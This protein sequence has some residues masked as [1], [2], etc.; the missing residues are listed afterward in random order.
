MK[1]TSFLAKRGKLWLF[2]YSVY[3]ALFFIYLLFIL[4]LE[5]YWAEINITVSGWVGID[6]N[7]ILLI[8]LI[9]LA[10]L[11]YG[12]ILLTVNFRRFITSSEK[13]PHM[14]HKILPFFLIILYT[15]LIII[16][17]ELLEDYKYVIFQFFEFYSYFIFLGLDIGLLLLLYPLIHQI[18][19]ISFD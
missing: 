14:F 2:F 16:F 17:I 10:P 15:L 4:T 5:P 3:I 8:F 9:I 7:I 18:N 1:L 19:L 13:R 6:F 12:I 11:I